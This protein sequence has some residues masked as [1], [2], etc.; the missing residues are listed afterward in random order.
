MATTENAVRSRTMGPNDIGK[1]PI[2]MESR[3]PPLSTKANMLW[4]SIGSMTYLGCQW[5]TTV[6]VVRLSSNYDDAGLLSLAMS[7]SAIF[8]TLACYKMNTYQVSDVQHENTL[9]EYLGFRAVTLTIATVL[10]AIYTLLACPLSSF[11]TI[12]LYFGF[13][14]IALVIDVLHAVDQQRRRMDMIGVSFIL[15]GVSMLIAF[16]LVFWFSQSLNWA[17][18]SMAAT[19]LLVFVFYDIPRTRVFERF[20]VRISFKK[21]VYLL[22]RSF[23]AMLAS[24]ACSAIFTIPKQ[25]LL[26]L[27][28]DAALGIYSSVAAPALIVQMGATYLYQPL[29]DIFPRLYY[30]G[31]KKEFVRTFVLT[32][33]GIVLVGVVCYI[34]FGFV[35]DWFLVLLFGESIKPY[36][37]LLGPVVISSIATA[38]LW[39]LGDL[40]VSIR[41]FAGNFAGNV[42]AFVSVIPLGIICVNIW[43]MNG[44]SFAG[45]AACTLGSIVMFVFLLKKI[46]EMHAGRNGL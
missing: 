7:V 32:C 28:G 36:T 14:G 9:S 30:D 37:Y 21:V 25:Y 43:D 19:T 20:Q 46:R 1:K 34:V 16:I 12:M 29:I 11:A 39:F 17:I 42:V 10:C 23:S 2:G 45:T 31:K 18:V 44:V 3:Y 33:V 24:V 6:L 35:G 8:N 15:Q 26:V 27:F 5:L 22:K 13:K 38:F 40:L 4:N 41:C